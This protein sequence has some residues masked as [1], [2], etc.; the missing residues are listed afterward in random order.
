MRKRASPHNCAKKPNFKPR[1]GCALATVS[2]DFSQSIVLLSV[3]INRC[4]LFVAIVSLP[5]RVGYALLVTGIVLCISAFVF[6]AGTQLA[7][8]GIQSPVYEIIGIYP[9]GFEVTRIDL[10]SLELHW[11]DGCNARSSSLIKIALGIGSIIAGT[12]VIRR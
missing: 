12:T 11:Y 5:D 7:C 6:G 1:R 4:A 2:T 10:A 8:P 9:A 3:A